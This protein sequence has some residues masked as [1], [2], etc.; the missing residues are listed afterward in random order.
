[1]QRTERERSS[2]GGRSERTKKGTRSAEKRENEVLEVSVRSSWT[3]TTTGGTIWIRDARD[4]VNVV[5]LNPDEE[6]GET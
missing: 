1:M 4:V 5:A 6:E 3:Y 2:R